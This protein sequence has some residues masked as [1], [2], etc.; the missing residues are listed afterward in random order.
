MRWPIDCLIGIM[1]FLNVDE[2]IAIIPKFVIKQAD[3]VI[4]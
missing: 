3:V 1:S 4:G 2:R